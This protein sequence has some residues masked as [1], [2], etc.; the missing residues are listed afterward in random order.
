[1]RLARRSRVG[2][3][4]GG[5]LRPPWTRLRA[6]QGWALTR[7]RRRDDAVL[8]HRLEGGH[9]TQG[10]LLQG[11]LWFLYRNHRPINDLTAGSGASTRF[12]VSVIGTC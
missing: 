1:M 9:V 12:Q 7:R 2:D 11:N 4:W 5:G 8:T 6:A 3:R 10:G